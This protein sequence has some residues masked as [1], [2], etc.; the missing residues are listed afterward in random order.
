MKRIALII[1]LVTQFHVAQA[2]P[3]E[4]VT[5][6]L[7]TAVEKLARAH[8]QQGACGDVEV[9]TT[10][11][12]NLLRETKIVGDD[13]A[14]EKIKSTPIIGKALN[15]SLGYREITRQVTWENA[16]ALQKSLDGVVM[17]GPARGA[18]G[19]TTT[20][21]FQKNGKV[22]FGSLELLDEEPYTRWNTEVG[23]YSLE[24]Q[25]YAVIVTLN[26]SDVQG[27]KFLLTEYNGL[28]SLIPVEDEEGNPY[29]N[30]YVDVPSECDA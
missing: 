24:F 2:G 19:N 8:D 4:E 9:Y 7:V 10:T 12:L 25:D 18:Y 30:G 5:D 14:V 22:I 1:A 6:H 11:L 15:H 27:A 29:M 23:T 21:T 17:F 3:A 16:E 13:Y 26:S 20:V 28:W